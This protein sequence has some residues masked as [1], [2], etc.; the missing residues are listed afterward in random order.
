M[1]IKVEADELMMTKLLSHWSEKLHQILVA[2]IQKTAPH[3]QSVRR[4]PL[5][6]DVINIVMYY[7]A[8]SIPYDA[9]T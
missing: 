7:E 5:A 4:C 3:I 2:R 1:G 6:S 8:G 9:H